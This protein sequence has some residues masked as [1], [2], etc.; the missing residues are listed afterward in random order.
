MDDAERHL[1]DRGLGVA[2]KGRHDNGWG[3]TY[4]DT[5]NEL[6]VMICVRQSPRL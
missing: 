2:W 4:F 5:F 1:I 6:G 3:F